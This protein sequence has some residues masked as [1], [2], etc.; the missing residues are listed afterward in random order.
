MLLLVS[1]ASAQAKPVGKLDTWT[2]NKVSSREKDDEVL[3]ISYKMR[4]SKNKGSDRIV[5]EFEETEVP[6][7][8]VYFTKP[9]ITIDPVH[10]ENASKPKK[11]EI[12][13]VKGNAFVIVDFA[14]G[15]RGKDAAAKFAGE[16]D[17]TVVQDIE[18]V[19][20]FENFFSIAVGLRSRKMFRVQELSNPTRLVVDFKY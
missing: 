19:D 13:K 11:D 10:L 15:F 4:V 12:I 14:L 16:Q 9:P 2:F 1:L 3:P 17:L 7:Y 5:F 18:S 20:W 8:T 6:E